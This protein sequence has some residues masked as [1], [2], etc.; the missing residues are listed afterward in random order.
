MAPEIRSHFDGAN[1]TNHGK[2]TYHFKKFKTKKFSLTRKLDTIRK[3]GQTSE[4]AE[5]KLTAFL[6]EH[7]LPFLL[8]D[9]LPLLCAS[10]FANSQI[11]KKFKIKR[12]KLQSWKL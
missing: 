12:K 3:N 6:A 8:M 4:S 9:H 10:A 2:S 1:S 11:A 5:L 7:N